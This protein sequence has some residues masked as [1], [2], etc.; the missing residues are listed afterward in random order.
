MCPLNDTSPKSHEEIIYN[1]HS[2][3]T[4]VKWI[5][6]E[7]ER[8]KRN[9]HVV[10]IHDTTSLNYLKR[11]KITIDY[12]QINILIALCAGMCVLKRWCHGPIIKHQVLCFIPKGRQPIQ[13][14]SSVLG[15]DILNN[16]RNNYY[17][18]AKK[19]KSYVSKLPRAFVFQCA[20][21]SAKFKV[22]IFLLA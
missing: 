20:F 6:K 9:V 19:N 10:H 1:T 22:W 8:K 5:K 3:S 12:V 16:P 14:Q 18:K 21:D 17:G 7:R 15:A 13:D 4:P 2:C 11:A